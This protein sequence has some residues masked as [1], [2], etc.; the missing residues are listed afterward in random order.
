MSLARCLALVCWAW[1]TAPAAAEIY[2]CEDAAGT[3]LF[4]ED[5]R[6]CPEAAPVPPLRALPRLDPGPPPPARGARV[7]EGADELENVFVPVALLE[8]RWE[9]L[10][11]APS[12]PRSDP[13]LRALGVRAE[14]TRYYTRY[15]GPV[16]Q[17]CTVGLWAF[18]SPEQ[19]ALALRSLTRPNWR[20]LRQAE[21]LITL[22]A[23]TLDRTR[24]STREI[25]EACDRIGARTRER[26][27]ARGSGRRPD[28]ARP[29]APR[30]D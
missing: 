19:A 5:P 30:S 23:V 13:D 18:A 14:Q 29:P 7:A 22:H 17:V 8:G 6:A 28:V 25:F 2:R 15:R 24:G 12:D 3:P 1:L 9:V 10:R 11:D 27:A 26:A 16:S 21:L 4:T 20:F